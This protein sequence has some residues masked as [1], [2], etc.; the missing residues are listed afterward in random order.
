MNAEPRRNTALL[1]IL[2][3]LSLAGAWGAR[4]WRNAQEAKVVART[5]VLLADLELHKAELTAI[6][7]SL[8]GVH[9]P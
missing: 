5:E 9:A 1:L 7:D 8:R 3:V 2:V 6:L 4:Q